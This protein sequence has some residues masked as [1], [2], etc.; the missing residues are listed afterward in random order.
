MLR[1]LSGD[2]IQFSELGTKTAA[3]KVLGPADWFHTECFSA[4]WRGMVS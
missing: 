3:L 2:L 4:D 1:F